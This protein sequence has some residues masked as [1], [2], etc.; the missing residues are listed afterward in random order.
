LGLIAV[1][2]LQAAFIWIRHYLMSWLG[3]RV[4]SDLRVRVF[5]KLLT[6]PPSWFH[7]RHTGEI[8]SRLSSD[9]TVVDG[10]VG[11]ELSLALRHT[12]TLAGGIALLLFENWQL[13]L[14]M[15]AIVPPLMVGVVVFGRKVRVMARAVQDRHAATAARVEEVVGAMQT[16][17][18]F[19]REQDEAVRYR[20]N[21]DL[22]LVQ[23]FQ[24]IRWRS[25]LFSVFNLAV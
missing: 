15:L 6:L 21:I 13:T 5:S 20:Q 14:M 19:V 10:L 17:Q 2:V 4:V 18:A 9:V 1:F 24:L 25:S 3:E 8:L 23:S 22:G 11:T 16:V 7:Q 12:V